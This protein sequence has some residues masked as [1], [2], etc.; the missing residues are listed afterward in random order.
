MCE[1]MVD[2]DLRQMRVEVD[3]LGNMSEMDRF[4]MK[5][6]RSSRKEEC[7]RDDVLV[8]S[9]KSVYCELCQKL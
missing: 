5:A 6:I 1:G 4:E 9:N 8:V 3:V 2:E 7:W